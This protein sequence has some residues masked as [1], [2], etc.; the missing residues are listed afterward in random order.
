MN[1]T[2]VKWSLLTKDNHPQDE[3]EFLTALDIDGTA[4]FDKCKWYKKGSKVECQVKEE[5]RKKPDKNMPAPDRLMLSLFGD[6]QEY[7]IEEDGFYRV[8]GDFLRNSDKDTIFLEIP[9]LYGTYGNKI[10]WAPLPI[11]PKGLKHPY[12]EDLEDKYEEEDRKIRKQ[13]EKKEFLKGLDKEFEPGG[14]IERTFMDIETA[15]HM[16]SPS[17]KASKEHPNA[18]GYRGIYLD[19]GYRGIYLENDPALNKQIVVAAAQSVEILRGLQEKYSNDD[20]IRA[21][22]KERAGNKEELLHMDED[23]IKYIESHDISGLGDRANSIYVRWL[24]Q[25]F[26]TY[27]Y[28]GRPMEWWNNWLSHNKSFKEKPTWQRIAASYGANE[29]SWKVHRCLKLIELGA[30]SII[31][32]NEMRTLTEYLMLMLAN[33]VA[34]TD[35]FGEVFG[36]DTDGKYLDLPDKVMKE[37]GTVVDEPPMPDD[38]PLYDEDGMPLYYDYDPDEDKWYVSCEVEN[39]DI[40]ERSKA[41]MENLKAVLEGICG[42]E[43]EDIESLISHLKESLIKENSYIDVVKQKDDRLLLSVA[44]DLG[45]YDCLSMPVIKLKKGSLTPVSASLTI[46]SIRD[47]DM[48]PNCYIATAAK[49]NE[50]DMMY[51]MIPN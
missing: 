19:I 3:A 51:F 20:I 41:H 33:K 18:I 4:S 22:S 43:Y 44:A 31:L 45:L 23:I 1:Y 26:I 35:E 38:L 39:E 16:I 47:A 49:K 30:P 25:T 13:E 24:F 15:K 14:V 50:D 10:Y 42:I 9:E 37:D 32:Q 40:I 28:G 21:K 2:A 7:E 17:E 29:A 36:Y 27:P 5:Y 12:E 11:A 48:M 34:Y 46:K 8:T 6:C